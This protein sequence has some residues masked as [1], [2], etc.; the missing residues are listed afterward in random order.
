MRFLTGCFLTAF[1]LVSCNYTFAQTG[2]SGIHGKV[3]DEKHLAAE[4]ATV[5]LLAAADSAIIKST[6]CDVNGLFSIDVQPGKYLLLISKIGFDQSLTGPYVIETGKNIDVKEISLVLHLPQLKEVSIT[7][8]RSYIYARPGKVILNVQSSIIAEGN[9]VAEILRQAPGVH[10][11]T[12]GNF[13]IIGRQG[14]LVTIDGK[15]TNLSGSDLSD[16]LQGMPGSTVQQIEL[17]TNTSA[18]YDAAAGGVINIIS[19]KGLNAG[20]NVTVNGGAGYGKY[21]KANAGLTFN[22]RMGAFNIFGNYNYLENKSFHDFTT[23]RV[24]NY[25]GLSSV[26]D[27]S[28]DAVQ[29]SKNHTYRFGTDV[30]VSPNHTIGFL[31]SGTI[32]NNNYVKNNVLNMSNQ[33]KLDSVISTTSLT[34]RGLSNT[35]YDINYAGKLDDKGKMLLA[36]FVFNDVD[37][38]SSEYIDNYFNLANGGSYR[39]PLYLQNLTPSDIHI[40]TAKLDFISPLSKTAQ[41]EAGIKYSDVRSNNNLVFGPKVGDVY[42]SSPK[43]SNTFIYT[44][45]IN[46]AYVS[47]TGKVG[48]VGLIAGLRAEQTISKGN[49]LT[50]MSSVKKNYLNLFPQVQLNYVI[51]DKNDINI[52]FNRGVSR[53][54]YQMI[55]PFLSYVDLYDYYAGNPNLSPQYSNKVE[56]THTYNKVFQT[57]L[58]GTVITDF[59]DLRVLQ[60]NDSSKVSITNAKNF[61][62]YSILGL[63]I[64]TPAS[65]TP[66][67]HA[68]F[69]LD[70]S[71]QRI[72]AY[73]ANGNLNKGTQDI[74]FSS[75][76]TFKVS[77]TLTAELSGRYESPN[78]YGIGQLKSNYWISAGISKQVLNKKGTIKLTALDIFNTYRD[79]STVKY[80]NLDMKI[81]DKVETRIFRIGFTYRFGNTSLKSST[82]HDTSNEEEQERAAGG[83]AGKTA[84]N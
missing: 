56:L 42:T 50:A 71:Y 80:Q 58:Y 3:S 38:H 53:A 2:P 14:A 75:I 62:T 64:I 39:P 16:M 21:Y 55:N 4:A 49:S 76:Q 72:K 20:T 45:N 78:F 84:V 6:P 79:R 19:K 44:E 36:D 32:S 27:V 34:N 81:Y 51:N 43:F 66:W 24:I 59:Y 54:I 17:I 65:F 1:L 26:Y 40:W 35:S 5:I 77:S 37:R 8:Q 10:V 82:K 73:A 60:Q 57:T 23:N 11:D 69:S 7:A 12:R 70:A 48:E 74:I 29:V 31:I 22:N 9:S 46:S 52:S 83:V 30:V 25:K 33:G 61:G 18:K 28:Y 13:S 15:P 67:W 41:L 63:K 68:S 47:Y